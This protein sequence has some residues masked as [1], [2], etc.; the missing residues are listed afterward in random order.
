V[1][2]TIVRDVIN[3][4]PLGMRPYSKAS[5][6]D[7]PGAFWGI[8]LPEMMS[9][10]QLICNAAARALANNMGIASGP[11]I[12]VSVDR[13]PPGEP[14]TRMFPWKIWQ[15]TSDRTGGGQPAIRFF[16]PEMRAQELLGIYSHFSKVAD[17]VTG[18]PN[19]IYGSSAVG[20]A[21][22]TASGLSMLMENAAKG[23]KHAILNLDG[24]V[25]ELIR[26]IYVHLMMFDPDDSIKGDMHLIASGTIGAMIREQQQIA[27]REFM[28]ATLNPFDAQIIGPAGR[29]HMLREAARGIFPDIDKVVPDPQKMMAAMQAQAGMGGQQGPQQG[30][31]PGAQ[32]P[33]QEL[34]PD[35]EMPI[36]A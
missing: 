22:R 5:F 29:A 26:R 32:P 15:T 30:P 8:A 7:R 16:Q 34:P 35:A 9:D 36:P 12:E 33:E 4:D 21:G 1:A 23:I 24:A 6:E 28:A 31:P 17:E 10:V 3:P 20:G 19:Y 25:A 2:D 14:I 18:V 13:L 27:R 11:Q